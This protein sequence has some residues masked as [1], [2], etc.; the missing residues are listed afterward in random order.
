MCDTLKILEIL[1]EDCPDEPMG[2]E[3]VL[4]LIEMVYAAEN[5][6]K[7]LNDRQKN[8]LA[9]IKREELEELAAY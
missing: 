9:S 8:V 4:D 5:P 1:I 6:I 3:Q 7:L 2:K